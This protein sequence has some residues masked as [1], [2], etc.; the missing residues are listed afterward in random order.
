MMLKKVKLKI[1]QNT[2]FPKKRRGQ[3]TIFIIIAIL[4]VSLVALFFIFKDK[5]IG[6]AIPSEISPIH[7]T[8]VSCLQED[9]SL[10]VNLL[11]SQGG[12]IY[13]PEYDP[14]SEYMPFSSQ[15]DFLGN[16]IPYWYYVSGNNIEREQVPSKAEMQNQLATLIENRAR[17]CVFD[18]YY[19]QGY[20]IS[21]DE[22]NASVEITNSQ[23][24][25]NL[26]MD[27]AVSRGEESYDIKEHKVVLNSD[28]GSLYNSALKVYNEEQSK[29]FLEN[30]AVDTLRLYAP[31]DG[32][33]MTCSPKTWIANDVFSELQ[34]AIEA[35]TLALKNSDTKKDYFDVQI[36][37]IPSDQKVRFLNSPNWSYSL[38][39]LPSQEN[40][41]IANPVGNQQ[42]LGILGFCYVPYHFVYN[43]KYPVLVQVSSGGEIFQFPLA[44]IIQRN[45]PRNVS[46]GE[47]VQLED[48]ELC[49][50]KNTLTNISVYDSN[51]KPVEASISYECLG[52]KCNIGDTK[53]GKISEEFP[54]C[55][56]GFVDVRA[57]G[58]GDAQVLYST[59][60]E[61]ILNIYLTKLY[62][63]NIQL[64]I[65]GQNYNKDA[66]I[67]FVSGDSSKTI[68]YPLQKNVSLG[69]GT[70]NVQVYVYKNSSLQL[71]ATTQQQCVDVPSSSIGGILGLTKQQCFDVQIPAQIISN[72]LSGG[73]QA[74][75]TFSENDLKNSNTINIYAESLPSP[76]SLQQLQTNYVLFDSKSLDIEIK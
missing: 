69:E 8:L 70:Y 26:K 6:N 18:N 66:V 53:V 41:M 52:T 12:Y 36:S 11:E 21:M 16:P 61:G 74:N 13:L 50:D 10:G 24:V 4:I 23:V 63:K 34:N 57:D 35:N 32:V 68:L 71:G 45:Q 3:V 76:D 55:V 7:N 64:K 65:D 25:L 39:V 40:I 72:A 67:Y 49:K 27:F 44:V 33:E 54:Q 51:S 62:N 5:I 9:L 75:Y 42:G 46:G 14:G 59:T 48:T 1:S 28:L 56:N 31:V 73:G 58:Y 37:G 29:L 38:E 19:N 60:T 2:F 22:P 15:L 47:A 20:E 17:T 43:V 30:Y